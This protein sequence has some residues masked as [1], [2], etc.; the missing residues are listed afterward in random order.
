M[1]ILKIV[2][3]SL[4]TERLRTTGVDFRTRRRLRRRQ[5]KNKGPNF[6]WH[7]DCYDKL[8]P[9]GICISRCIDG[10]SRK[11]IWLRAGQNSN[12]PKIIA[13]YYI[14]ALH[15]IGGCSQTIRADLGTE[16][17]VVIEIQTS[18]IEIRGGAGSS[19]P[20]F[21]YGTSPSNQRIEAWWAILRK[22][23]SQYWMNVFQ[24]LKEDGLFSGSFLEKA[25][26]QFCFMRIIPDELDDVVTEWDTH[27]LSTSRNSISKRQALYHVSHATNLFHKRLL[28]FNTHIFPSCSKNDENT[29][30]REVEEGPPFQWPKF[31]VTKEKLS[32]FE[33]YDLVDHKKIKDHVEGI[34]TPDEDPYPDPPVSIL[35]SPKARAIKATQT[36]ISIEYQKGVTHLAPSNVG[37]DFLDLPL[38]YLGDVLS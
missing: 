26:V 18:L 10:F 15:R 21:L 1:A 16:N 9:Y 20:P 36:P 25:L 8:K 33:F 34:L 29:V 12:N 5:Y 4:S 17:G 22:H 31:Y 38:P 23:H 11:I 35:S 32:D 2:K 28:T 7:M 27:R 19:L 14:D 24:V 30:L 3:W 13:G 37:P 6:L